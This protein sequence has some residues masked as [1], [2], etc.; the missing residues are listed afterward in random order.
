[1]IA[2]IK[3]L[4]PILSIICFV[5]VLLFL[6]K[7]DITIGTAL[8]HAVK[9]ASFQK[10]DKINTIYKNGGILLIVV[11]FVLGFIYVFNLF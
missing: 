7:P 4:L 10:T 6:R 8:L 5:S 9:R 2:T 11:G 1:M 3:A